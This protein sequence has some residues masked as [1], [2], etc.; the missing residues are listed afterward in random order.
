MIKYNTLLGAEHLNKEAR[1]LRDGL[2]TILKG[3]HCTKC[4][5]DTI[6]SFEDDG[7]GYLKEKI[8]P[9]CPE[10]LLRIRKKAFPN[11]L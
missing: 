1:E 11:S 7:Y 10:F 2:K 3:M 5:T 4:K 9:C 8:I 6:I